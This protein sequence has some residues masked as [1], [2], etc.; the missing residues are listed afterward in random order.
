ME[1]IL[2]PFHTYAAINICLSYTVCL[3][4]TPELRP[5]PLNEDACSPGI[6]TG[7]STAVSRFPGFLKR[8]QHEETCFTFMQHS[9]SAINVHLITSVLSKCKCCSIKIQAQA[10]NETYNF[11]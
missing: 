5:S 11:C 8:T 6:N 3:Q 4:L 1:I 7:V 10:T 9:H 2:P